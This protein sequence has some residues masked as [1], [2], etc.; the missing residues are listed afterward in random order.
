M[1]L[2]PLHVVK[3]QGLSLVLLSALWL[4]GGERMQTIGRV[5]IKLAV[6]DRGEVA[7]LLAESGR[8]G[9]RAV[10]GKVGSMTAEKVVA[11]VET[12]VQREQLLES[13]YRHVHS[14]YHAIIEA[15]YGVCRGQLELGE[16]LRTVGLNF[17]MVRG[18]RMLPAGDDDGEWLAVALYGTIG[19]PKKGFEHEVIGLG[20]NHL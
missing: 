2:A 3:A 4:A 6:A 1:D 11:A 9:Y 15:F 14:L 8:M 7:A 19:A 17:A 10:V 13:G 5:A 12:A 20:I 18:P 16:I